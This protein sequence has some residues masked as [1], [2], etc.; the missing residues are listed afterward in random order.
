MSASQEGLDRE[1]LAA[2]VVTQLTIGAAVIQPTLA[3][4][5]LV[6]LRAALAPPVQVCTEPCQH[7]HRRIRLTSKSGKQLTEQDLEQLR[8]GLD[9]LLG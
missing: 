5:D 2:G 3:L 6:R 1:L 7:P 9:L 4:H 8:Q